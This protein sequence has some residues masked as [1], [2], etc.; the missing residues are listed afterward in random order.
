MPT[1]KRDYRFV[2]G[3]AT[4]F[5]IS[6]TVPNLEKGMEYFR[7][8]F[9][10]EPYLVQENASRNFNLRGKTVEQAVSK[11]ACYYAGPVRFE[12]TEPVS[13][14]SVYAEFLNK[15]GPGVQHIGIRVSDR[16]REVAQLKERGVGVQQSMEVPFIPLK[17]AYMDTMDDLGFNIELVECPYVPATPEFEEYVKVKIESRMLKKAAEGPSHA[18]K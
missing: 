2:G 17:M 14:D 4:V 1:N 11:I 9:G 7:K 16:D 18:K 5:E 12:L 10:W 3:E 15:R 13:G 6:I 8:A